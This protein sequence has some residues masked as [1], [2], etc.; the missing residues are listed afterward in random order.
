MVDVKHMA[1]KS[2]KK[3]SK[4]PE[5]LD[6]E[7]MDID[8]SDKSNLVTFQDTNYVIIEYLDNGVKAEHE[9]ETE[10]EKKNEETGKSEKVKG[11]KVLVCADFLVNQMYPPKAVG[12]NKTFS[13][14]W[15]R[16]IELH[17]KLAKRL[18]EEK[19][20]FIG[21]KAKVE[22]VGSKWDTH[23]I[24]TI[25]KKFGFSDGVNKFSSNPDLLAPKSDELDF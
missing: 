4:K 5:N 3:G 1:E 13:I 7:W 23:Y 10:I 19:R 21:L 14:A 25:P 16:L 12:K 8:S 6:F 24:I 22:R 20:E 2:E 9:I 15:N 11:T 17:K 18:V